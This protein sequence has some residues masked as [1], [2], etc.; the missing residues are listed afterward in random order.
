[1][2]CFFII[3]LYSIFSSIFYSM[4]FWF[5]YSIPISILLYAVLFIYTVFCFY[6]LPISIL[7][8]PL[9]PRQ[10]PC[11]SVPCHS[12]SNISSRLKSGVVLSLLHHLLLIFHPLFYLRVS[13]PPSFS[14]YHSLLIFHYSFKPHRLVSFPLHIEF[15]FSRFLIPCWY[16]ISRLSLAHC[17]LPLRRSVFRDAGMLGADCVRCFGIYT[18]G[19]VDLVKKN[20]CP[21]LWYVRLMNIF[22]PQRW[23]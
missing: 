23:Q 11:C 6:S 12:Y 13:F 3:F 7:F 14:F 10:S 2:L 21:R 8:S 20:D 15:G 16:F 4:L 18:R 5:F 9:F 1:M 17:P 22:N 19:K